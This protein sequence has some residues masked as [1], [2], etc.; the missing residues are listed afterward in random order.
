MLQAMKQTKTTPALQRHHARDLPG[1]RCQHITSSSAYRMPMT[2]TIQAGLARSPAAAVYGT[3]RW[4]RRLLTSNPRRRPDPPS[5]DSSLTDL[6][7][8]S[9][10]RSAWTTQARTA[11]TTQQTTR[12]RSIEEAAR[13]FRQ[14]DDVDAQVLRLGRRDARTCAVEAAE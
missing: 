10:S 14:E 8:L 6:V 3:A 4:G 12:T 1:P 11:W 9:P 2:S 7:V 13:A 5:T